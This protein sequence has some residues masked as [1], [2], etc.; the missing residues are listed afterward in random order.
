MVRLPNLQ[1]SSV[2]RSMKGWS[3]EN[4]EYPSVARASATLL[5]DL[6][7]K[8]NLTN[9]KVIYDKILQFK[10]CST[11]H[12][13]PIWIVLDS[14]CQDEGV[15]L[16]Y[17]SRSLEKP[18]SP[19]LPHS[20]HAPQIWSLPSNAVACPHLHKWHLLG[21]LWWCN[22]SHVWF[23]GSKNLMKSFSYVWQNQ[24]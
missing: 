21:Y 9:T 6:G 20:M 18:P 17:H 23:G 7:A 3:P 15:C 16:E 2:Y 24:S 10:N 13:Q 11:H 22:L 14:L 19:S 4:T 1:Y 8:D 12:C 5:H